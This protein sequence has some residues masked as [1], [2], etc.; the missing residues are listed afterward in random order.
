MSLLSVMRLLG[1]R[2]YRMTLRY[3]EVTNETVGRE[4]FEA[5]TK[6]EKRYELRHPPTAP[7]GDAVGPATALA[8][9]IR[10]LQ[11]RGSGT[12]RERQARLLVRRLE[13]VRKEVTDLSQEEKAT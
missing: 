2:D 13:R 4:Y 8:E 9:M 6:V 1:H 7:A 10:W 5:L 11:R 3:A 12:P